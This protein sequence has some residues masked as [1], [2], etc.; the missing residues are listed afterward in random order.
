MERERLVQRRGTKNAT[1]IPL[2]RLIAASLMIIISN[3]APCLANG[4]EE[5]K[6]DA[7][8]AVTTTD[9]AIPVGELELWLTPLSRNEL[10]DEAEGW[11]R[12]L[13]NLRSVL[14]VSLDMRKVRP[15]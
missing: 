9:R 10:G 1:L 4:G 8:K 2:A 3:L 13:C 7:Q 5:G 14:E 15:L 11:R 12:R 6:P